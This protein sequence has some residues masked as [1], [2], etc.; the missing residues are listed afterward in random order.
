[1]SQTIDGITLQVEISCH[2]RRVTVLEIHPLST[3]LFQKTGRNKRHPIMPSHLQK[4]RLY[5]QIV[6]SESIRNLH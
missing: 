5:T 4:R 2:S 1:M 3:Q 6:T